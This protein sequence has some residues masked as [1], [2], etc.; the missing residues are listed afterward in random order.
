MRDQRPAGKQDPVKVDLKSVP[1][2]FE[3]HVLR[4][5]N[6]PL[7]PGIVDH[8]L[9]AAQ[10]FHGVM[11]QIADLRLGRNIAN[12]SQD[13]LTSLG[14]SGKGSV[15]P[16]QTVAISSAENNTRSICDKR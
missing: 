7:N 3:R 9:N 15:G 16:S 2:V 12:M 8:D 14:Q 10:L 4:R 6:R 1:P 13:L 5:T 11:N